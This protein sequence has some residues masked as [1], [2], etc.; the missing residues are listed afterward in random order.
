MNLDAALTL[1]AH[2][3]LGPARPGGAGPRPWR[4]TNIT[5]TGRGSVP[6]RTGGDGARGAAAAAR[7]PEGPRHVGLC[8]YLFEDMGFHGD[9]RRLLRRTQQLSERGDGPAQGH[10]DHAVGAGDG[11]GRP[12]GAGRGRRRAAGTFR[13]QGRGGRRRGAVRPVPRR[14]AADAGR[15]RAAGRAVGGPGFRGDARRPAAGA[16]GP[17]RHADVDEPQGRLPRATAISSG[18]FASWNGCASSTPTTRCSGATSA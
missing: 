5:P 15:L 2:E 1:L 11:G 12:G 14:P 10:P 17:H 6:R 3:P 18:P 13:G 8:R 4:A 16:A 9:D 7:R